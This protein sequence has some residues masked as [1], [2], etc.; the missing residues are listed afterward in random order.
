MKLKN[1]LLAASLLIIDFALILFAPIILSDGL[2]L[3]LLVLWFWMLL[4]TTNH[5]K[6]VFVSGLLLGA[7]ILVRPIAQFLPLVLILWWIWQ[8]MSKRLLLVML[9]GTFIL[10]AC[11]MTRNYVQFQTFSLSSMGSNNLLFYNASGIL[12]EENGQDLTTSQS[13]LARSAKATQDWENDPLATKKYLNYCKKSAIDIILEHPLIF[14]KQTAISAIL[15][16]FKPPRSYVDLALNLEYKYAPVQGLTNT[17]TFKE[18]LSGMWANTSSTALTLTFYQ[19][20]LN[21]IVF[22]FAMIAVFKSWKNNRW[23]SLIV[24]LVLYFWMTSLITQPDARFRMPMGIFLALLAGNVSLDSIRTMRFVVLT[25]SGCPNDSG[26]PGGFESPSEAR[27]SSC[28]LLSPSS[29]SS[30]F[31]SSSEEAFGLGFSLA[32]NS[33]WA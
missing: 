10:P 3:F 2:F 28:V 8:K 15:M 24:M 21:L 16:P 20:I 1:P 30:S 6:Y 9:A 23:I 5:K 29:S 26:F 33:A 19:L 31:P 11:W 4:Q 22:G 32:I 13:L 27:F 17:K 14:A 18:K 12:A 7:M 25:W